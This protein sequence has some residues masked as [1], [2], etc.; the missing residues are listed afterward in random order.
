M[1]HHFATHSAK[2]GTEA[3]GDHRGYDPLLNAFVFLSVVAGAA[4]M[5][6]Y[7]LPR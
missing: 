7:A 2:N 4:I 5:I 1:K 6:G 3:L